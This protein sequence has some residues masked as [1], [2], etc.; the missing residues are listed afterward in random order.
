MQDKY[1]STDIIFSLIFE[2]IYYNTFKTV[3]QDT[4]AC[5]MKELVTKEILLPTES[6]R[7]NLTDSKLR[8]NSGFTRVD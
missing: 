1:P 8:L 7:P 5:M 2:N 3:L 4:C 6:M